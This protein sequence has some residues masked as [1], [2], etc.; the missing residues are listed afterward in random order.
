MKVEVYYS[1]GWRSTCYYCGRWLP[2]P[3][4]FV[5]VVTASNL[6]AGYTPIC[7]DCDGADA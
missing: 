2:V 1:E 6:L 4:R 7:D 3:P 5:A